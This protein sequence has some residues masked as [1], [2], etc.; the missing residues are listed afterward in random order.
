VGTYGNRGLIEVRAPAHRVQVRDLG[1]IGAGA[2][3][4]G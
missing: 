3:Y 1:F 4:Q 2:G